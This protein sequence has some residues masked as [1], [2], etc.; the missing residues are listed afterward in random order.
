M[1][2]KL[3]LLFLILVFSAKAQEDIKF[4]ELRSKAK[5]AF[6]KGEFY[7]AYQNFDRA[8]QINP[9]CKECKERCDEL[10]KK[11]KQP[12][13]K[14][15]KPPSIS[16][17]NI[18]IPKEQPKLQKTIY[19]FQKPSTSK[20]KIESALKDTLINMVYLS[21]TEVTQKEWKVYCL[22]KR[23]EFPKIPEK[24]LNDDY[25]IIN[26]SWVEAKQ[27][28]EWISEKTGENYDLPTLIEWQTARQ[29]QKDVKSEAWIYSNAER[30]I[31]QPCTKNEFSN[32]LCDIEGN[33][34]EWLSDWSDK[35]FV[36]DSKLKTY[37]ED[38]EN[39]KNRIVA[40]CSYREETFL[41]K[42]EP[43][44]RSFDSSIHKDFIGF[45][46]VKRNF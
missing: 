22:E 9:S 8:L 7:L 10:V 33:V 3:I 30:T 23:I 13:G 40:G 17:E 31:H 6:L 36:E 44:I 46:L 2:S 43:Y 41:C 19:V 29:G 45:R 26:I 12:K 38:N 18:S 24:L 28:A 1:R 25:P 16:K 21:K 37:Y 39:F 5:L 15:L 35:G 42:E 20:I 4:I 32:G 14:F 34:S 27:Y 11:L